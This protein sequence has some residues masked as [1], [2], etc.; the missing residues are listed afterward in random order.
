VS[1]CETLLYTLAVSK[2]NLMQFLQYLLLKPVIGITVKM[3]YIW[4]IPAT[5]RFSSRVGDEATFSC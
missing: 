4:S 1:F 2:Q 5:G 3:G